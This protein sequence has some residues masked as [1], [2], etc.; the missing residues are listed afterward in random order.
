MRTIYIPYYEK[1]DINYNYLLLLH[2]EATVSDNSYFHD[3]V[4][5]KSLEKLTEQMNLDCADDKQSKKSEK[6]ISK[7][8]L[9]RMLKDSKYSNYF[10]FNPKDKEIHLRVNV[11]EFK[12][13]K[14]PFITLKSNEIDFL[15]SYNDK[16]MTR[17]Y[18]FLKYHCSKYGVINYTIKQSLSKLGYSTDSNEN[19]SQISSYNTIFFQNGAISIEPYIDENGKA[20][21]RYCLKK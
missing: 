15:I 5:Y 16:K 19:E 7:S 9:S 14:Q 10:K 20:R 1:A 8:T 18:I 21:N 3:V 4:K 6:H 13:N 17:Y 11:G 2:R 12:E